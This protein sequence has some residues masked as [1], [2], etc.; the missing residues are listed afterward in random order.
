MNLLDP[1][2]LLSPLN[3]ANPASPLNPNKIVGSAA[4]KTVETAGKSLTK[5]AVNIGTSKG[6]PTALKYAGKGLIGAG[7][8]A[9]TYHS[10]RS[11]TKGDTFSG[12]NSAIGAAALGA[13][14]IP[15]NVALKTTLIAIGVGA[16]AM[17]FAQSG[18]N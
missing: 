9:H 14:L 1:G 6:I 12:F 18:D 2:N 8:L 7:A 16:T 15:M 11:F 4:E 17:A 5:D 3:I 10:Y 13:S